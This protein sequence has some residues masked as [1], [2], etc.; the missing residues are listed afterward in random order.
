MASASVIRE[1][2]VSLGFSTDK[3]S[4]D[5]WDKTVTTATKNVLKLAA[6]VEATAVSIGAGVVAFANDLEK[7]YF[8][9]QRSGASA[10]GIKAIG[11]AAEQ[12]GISTEQAVGAVEALR[13][14]MRKNPGQDTFLRAL[15]VDT[16]DANGKLLETDRI[17]VNLGKTLAGM[18]IYRAEQVASEFGIDDKLL[19]AMTSPEFAQAV[20]NY[21]KLYSGTGLGEAVKESHAFMKDFRD[22]SYII[23]MLAYRIERV[24]M[25]RF[26][27]S[28]EWLAEWVQKN[29]P[30]IADRIVWVAEKIW[31][32]GEKGA[33]AIKWIIDKLMEWDH[34]TDGLSTKILFFAA[35]LQL[36]GGGAIIGGIL[37][38]AGA[39]VRLGA[40]ILGIGASAG[41][42]G[43][44]GVLAG[45]MTLLRGLAR[46]LGL[47]AILAL[48]HSDNAGGEHEDADFAKMEAADRAARPEAYRSAGRTSA[49]EVVR[50][51]ESQGWSHDQAAGI[52]SNLLHESSFDPNAGAGTSHYG[53]A[54]W[55]TNRQKAFNDWAKTNAGGID[56][57]QSSAMQQ[58]QFLQYELTQGGEWRGGEHIRAAQ[59][60]S[61]AADAMYHYVER[62]DAL[63]T[64]ATAPLRRAD[65]V[66]IAQQTT[67]NVNA[68]DPATAGRA[69]AEAQGGV[70]QNLVRSFVNGIR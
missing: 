14:Y 7:L 5:E 69:V 70:N 37:S 58:L 28:L 9:S 53:L 39:F 2:L 55:D 35:T 61:A 26:K 16:R 51:F 41:A 60:A 63:G 19:L 59:N 44:G 17:F 11:A 21:R 67:I 4:W 18:P 10:E 6:A 32:L 25:A 22:L 43:A 42:A 12:M 49:A 24:L 38:L 56:I 20:E 47:G 33:K 3:R 15:G 54:Q 8:Q 68:P 30:M 65:A 64:D 40:A 34:Q 31:D 48:F 66:Q 29:G 23:G 50:F 1:Y 57:H 36:L 13:T 27:I 45:P 46:T 52:A 62:A